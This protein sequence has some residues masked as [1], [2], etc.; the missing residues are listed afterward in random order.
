[1]RYYIVINTRD[2]GFVDFNE[3]NESCVN[4]V[5]QSLNFELTLIS[6]DGWGNYPS[7]LENCEGHR[8]FMTRLETR[9]MLQNTGW[10]EIDEDIIE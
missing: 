2:I 9:K 5:I 8:G 7:F 4:G 1:M 6:F 3:V 10:T